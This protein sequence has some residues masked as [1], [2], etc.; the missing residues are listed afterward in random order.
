[1]NI[2]KIN[3]VLIGQTYAQKSLTF[4]INSIDRI[5]KLEKSRITLTYYGSSSLESI[6]PDSKVDFIT[7]MGW[8]HPDSLKDKI[9]SFDFA[10]LPYFEDDNFIVGELSFPSKFILYSHANLPVYYIGNT[11]S[12]VAKLISYNNLGIVQSSNTDS[13]DLTHH[14][15]LDTCRLKNNLEFQS[16]S[17]LLNKSQFSQ[18]A[19]IDSLK[20]LSLFK[21][22][23]TG[24]IRNDKNADYDI[25]AFFAEN[26]R[27]DNRKI[28]LLFT[29]TYLRI[30][31]ILNRFLN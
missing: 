25:N 5:N 22:L 12:S 17:N 8:E 2:H 15:I 29:R 10:F 1:M 9:K 31:Q 7:H 23:R 19:F 6:Y 13:L 20:K 27:G 3:C 24:P 30:A 26:T 18:L 4:F 11:N 14:N 28:S 21:D 16:T